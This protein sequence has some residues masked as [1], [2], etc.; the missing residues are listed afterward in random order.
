MTLMPGDIVS[1]GTPQGIDPMQRGDE[2]EVRVEHV[3]SLIN[4][5]K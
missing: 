3:G 1:T 4:T 5:I 2:I